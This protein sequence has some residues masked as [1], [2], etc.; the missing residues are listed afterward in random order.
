MYELITFQKNDS[1]KGIDKKKFKH[2]LSDAF[3]K[4]LVEDYFEYSKPI[5][6]IIAKDSN[7]YRCITRAFQ[8]PG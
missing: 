4:K 3:Q 7:D 8:P 5:L 1:F 6:V 2:L